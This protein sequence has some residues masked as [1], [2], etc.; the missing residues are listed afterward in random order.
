MKSIRLNALF[1]RPA[2][3]EGKDKLTCVCASVVTVTTSAK[4]NQNTHA[5]EYGKS[6]M[7]NWISIDRA[8]P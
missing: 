8:S 5:H 1:A 2:W 6:S 3:E 7:A 4:I